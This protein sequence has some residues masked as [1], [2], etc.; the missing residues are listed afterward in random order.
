VKNAYQCLAIDEQRA[1]FPATLWDPLPAPAP[2]QQPL[3]TLEQIWF[4]GFWTI[5]H[6]HA[7]FL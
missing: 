4:A 7:I 3:Q 1:Q 6:I 2:G 5:E